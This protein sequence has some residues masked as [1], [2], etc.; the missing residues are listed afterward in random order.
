MANHNPGKSVLK[1]ASYSSRT[2]S[3]MKYTKAPAPVTNVAKVMKAGD[4]PERM[5]N[6]YAQKRYE[7]LSKEG[8]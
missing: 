3:K 4:R 5:A 7:Q 2:M 1:P 8:Y 6:K